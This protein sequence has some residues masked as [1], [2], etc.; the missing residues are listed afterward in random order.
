MAVNFGSIVEAGITTLPQVPTVEGVVEG[1][2]V[3][4][5]VP[6]GVLVIVDVGV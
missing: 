2:G 5:P 6:V 4:E 1:V 3:I